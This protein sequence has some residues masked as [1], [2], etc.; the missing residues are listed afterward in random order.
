MRDGEAL[1]HHI[2]DFERRSS[3]EN[4]AVEPCLN[5][6]LDGLACQ[7]IAIERGVDPFAEARQALDVIRVFVGDKDSMETF[8]CSSDRGQALPDLA[9]AESGVDQQSRFVG[10]DVRTIASRTA[11]EDGESHRHVEDVRWGW[12]IEQ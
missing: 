12:S 1:D 6:R 2:A 9:P 3:A 7:P 11:S 4:P 10:L 8:G 5:L